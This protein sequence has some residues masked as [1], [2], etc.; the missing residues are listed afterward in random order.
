MV[1]GAGTKHYFHQSHIYSVAAMT[2]SVGAVV[3]RYRYGAKGAWAK[4]GKGC[5]AKGA[6]GKG[7]QASN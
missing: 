4:G 5:Q 7:C 2:N 3:E 1:S 6:T